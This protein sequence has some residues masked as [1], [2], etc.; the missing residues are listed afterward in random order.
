MNEPYEDD[1]YD[2][3]ENYHSSQN[4]SGVSTTFNLML[5][6]GITGYLRSLKI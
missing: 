4:N 3:E 2:E 1:N 5:M 6:L